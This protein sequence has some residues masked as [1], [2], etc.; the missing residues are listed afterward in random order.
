MAKKGGDPHTSPNIDALD[1][2]GFQQI[3]GM[4]TG[5]SVTPSP[6]LSGATIAQQVGGKYDTN[7]KHIIFP[8][9][10]KAKLN[11]TSGKYELITK[12]GNIDLPNRSD[13]T[14][15]LSLVNNA[16][17]KFKT[18]VY[19]NPKSTYN[20]FTSQNDL[21]YNPKTGKY[22]SVDNVGD[23]PTLNSDYYMGKY[24][25]FYDQNY[26]PT[27]FD[28]NQVETLDP[29]SDQIRKNMYQSGADQIV[30]NFQNVANSRESWINQQGQNLSSGRAEKLRQDDELSKNAELSGLKRRTDTEFEIRN[31]EDA[32]KV[33]DENASRMERAQSAQ[34]SANQFGAGFNYNRGKD[35]LATAEAIDSGVRDRAFGELQAN[36]QENANKITSLDDLLRIYAGMD[37][38]AAQLQAA[39]AQGYGSALGGLFGAA[40]R[41]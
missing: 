40:S 4:L 21:V 17:D 38:T 26:T 28:T 16:Y 20:L 23:V 12:V 22:D 19:D 15:Y 18:N 27:T 41:S 31:W 32:Q 39:K 8:D 14:D 3:M 2:I 7:K 25:D 36:R 29:L 35:R 5:Q 13:G 34:E 37:S 9:G 1:N 6:D 11:P 30:K 33:R 10:T 24:G